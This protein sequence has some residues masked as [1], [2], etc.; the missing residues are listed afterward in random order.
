MKKIMLFGLLCSAVFTLSSCA[1]GLYNFFGRDDTVRTRAESLVQETA[2]ST[3]TAADTVYT[4]AVITDVHFGAD[5]SRSVDDAF[6]SW[7]D[8]LSKKTPSEL[9]KFVLCL[10]DVAEHGYESEL[11]DY[12]AFCDK[13]QSAY[14]ITVYSVLG[15]HD[16]YN[17]GGSTGRKSCI[18]KR[19]LPF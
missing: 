14:G 19:R 5:K 7:L 2:P 9:P 12:K 8:G 17:N 11:N 13:I 18:R 6:L 1:Y 10:G 15:N 3:V 16:L 4:V